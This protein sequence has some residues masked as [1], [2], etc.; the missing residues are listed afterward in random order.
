MARRAPPTRC[1]TQRPPKV[2]L[3]VETSNAYAR[4]LLSGIEDFIRAHGPWNVYLSEHRRG[5]V[6]PAWLNDWDGDGVLARVESREIARA[7]QK[8]RLPVVDL[9]SHGFLPDSPVVTTDNEAIARL[10][11]EHFR[12]R[13]FR[14]VAFCGDVRFAWSRG[15]GETF[16]RLA[17]EAGLA[18]FGYQAG[19]DE[20]D[21]DAETDAIAKWLG[22]LTLPVAVFAC[23][24]YRGQ[25]VL[26]ACRRAELSVP[27]QVAVLGVDND[28]ILCQL[29]PPPLSSVIP[30]PHRSGW[31]AAELLAQMMGG[32]GSATG[33]TPHLAARSGHPAEHR[34]AFGG[35]CTDR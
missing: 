25:Q 31:A 16:M 34:Y 4:G 10:A 20:P 28:E 6:P 23:Y 3:L 7:L 11:Y 1:L 12:E 33:K 27:E 2:A 24:D 13:G 35:R 14:R 17:T 32:T 8:H 15:R 21:S 9:S 5:D 22:G 30:N 29:S 19:P 26:D 18:C